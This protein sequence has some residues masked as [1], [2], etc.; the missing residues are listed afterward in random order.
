MRVKVKM[1]KNDRRIWVT[2]QIA[3]LYVSKKRAVEDPDFTNEEFIAMN[4]EMSHEQLELAL[5]LPEGMLDE[6]NESDP[7][8]KLKKM[9][10]PELK[11]YADELGIEDV[12]KNKDGLISLILERLTE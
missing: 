10:V 12:P 8:V 11:A 2:T 7:E 6:S 9:T 1:L 3:D 5:A 4:P